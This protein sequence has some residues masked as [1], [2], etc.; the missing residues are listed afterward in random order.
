MQKT[1]KTLLVASALLFPITLYYFSPVLIIE[2]AAKGILVGSAI[3]F[4]LQFLSALFLGRAFCGWLCPGGG[5]QDFCATA[6]SKR[7]K[8]GGL[9]NIKYIIWTVWIA[10]IIAVLMLAGGFKSVDPLY[11]TVYGISMGDVFQFIIYYAVVALI[12]VTAFLAGRRAFCHYIC[13]M[14][15]FMVIGR[16]V[17]N[18]MRLPGLQLTAENSKCKSC[19]KCNVVCPM[20]LGVMDMVQKG[21][22]ENTECVLCG[23][24]K[25]SCSHGAIR[26]E[27]NKRSSKPKLEHNSKRNLV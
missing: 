16:K 22:M 25:S 12:V 3:M 15:P 4:T 23:E 6:V 11:G 5:I 24:C 14:A 10:A 7:A 17:R 8:G 1:R 19:K 18:A 20:S 27:F 21:E 9:D 2:G 26:L 13:W